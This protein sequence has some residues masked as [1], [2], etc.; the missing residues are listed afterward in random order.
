MRKVGI[1]DVINKLKLLTRK[2]NFNVYPGTL[3]CYNNKNNNGN[4]NTR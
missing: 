1:I 2:Y 3:S 4:N